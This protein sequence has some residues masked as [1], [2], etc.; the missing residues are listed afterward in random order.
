MAWNSVYDEV[1]SRRYTA[2]S[3]NWS[4]QK[5]GGFGVWLD[6]QFYHALLTGLFD[7]EVARE[8]LATAL[9]NA[10]PQGNLAC[11]VTARD[12][13]VDR[14]QIPIGSFIVRLLS[15]RLADRSLAALGYDVLARNHAWWWESRDPMRAGLASYGTSDVG[16]GLYK[17]TAFGARNESSMDNSPIHDEAEYDSVTRTLTTVDVGL[18]SLLA[19][20]AECLAALAECL[21]K[22]EEAATHA[23]RAEELRMRIRDVLWDG[24]RG[25][26]AN[27]LREGGFVRSVGPTSFFPLICGA[28]TPEQAAKLLAH[29][30]DPATFGGRL[31]LPSVSRD[32][33]AFAD[34]TYWRGR[35]WPPLNFIVWHGLRRYRFDAQARRL[36]E[37]SMAL[38]RQS[39]DSR[40]LCP[41][42]YNAD[43]GE[44]LDQ[45]DTEGFYGWGAL[46]PMLGVAEVIDVN[47]W[48]GWEVENSG[49][50]VSLGPVQTPAGSVSLRR[51]R[52]S[53]E[54]Q[55]GGLSLL[56]TTVPGR[57][58]HIKIEP[59][60]IEMRL[61]GLLP[62]GSTVTIPG[63]AARTAVLA[64][65]G[66]ASLTPGSDGV[67]ALPSSGLADRQRLLIVY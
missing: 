55:R 39:W 1:N 28:A 11:L 38:F 41:E 19:W 9:A 32:D 44:A 4:L 26:F 53:L 49:D 10:T 31:A 16:E 25:L 15:E 48:G 52:G 35:I 62:S 45:P 18:N 5:F 33:P 57:I 17:G 65:L 63:A 27:R 42:N 24:S 8:N 66:T 43:T 51:E 2:I 13:W 36:V 12:A 29:L 34:N 30:D 47:P 46:M 7:A 60:L 23:A 58:T 56:S 61:P 54:L 67:I 50:P 37:A 20:D 22:T 6:D 21:G 64:R 40:R 3:R 59:H 14:T